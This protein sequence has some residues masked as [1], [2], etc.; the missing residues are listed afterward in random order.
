MSA[1]G[2]QSGAIGRD[3]E[4]GSIASF[5]GAVPT[6]PSA[7]VIHGEAGIGKTT[8]WNDAVVSAG[9]ASYT[10]MSC[11]TARAEADL[12]YLSLGDLLG[13]VRD[14]VFAKLPAGVATTAPRGF[15]AE[16]LCCGSVRQSVSTG[17]FGW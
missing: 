7:L 6:R 2:D 14:E 11:R 9:R 17:C 5:L 3:A 15:D 8:L 13:T 16:A 10:V 1:E 4:L 12:P